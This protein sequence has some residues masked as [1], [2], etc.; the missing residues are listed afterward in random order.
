MD[1]SLLSK[2][3][4]GKRG[5]NQNLIRKASDRL[6]LDPVTVETF[7][8]MHPEKNRANTESPAPNPEI[9]ELKFKQ[10][11]MDA[12]Q[13]IA[14]WHH[15]AIL[16]LINLNDFVPDLKWVAKRLN[17]NPIEASSAIERLER[18]E[19]LEIRQDGSWVNTSGN[20]TTVG[21]PYTAAAL[22][23]MQKQILE[24]AI[25]AMEEV[26]A[27]NRDQ[28][29]MTMAVDMRRLPE[30]KERIKKFRRELCAFLEASDD[31]KAVKTEVCQLTISVFPVTRPAGEDGI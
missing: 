9:D 6:N 31:P 17:I 10:L 25:T 1:A 3:L 8:R 29:A 18:L 23:K 24:Q 19:M 27:E 4:S 14:D 16:E 13:V 7:V 21:G 11:T 26:P 30:A 28:S 20:N 2:V 15:F 5:I 22:R 12:F